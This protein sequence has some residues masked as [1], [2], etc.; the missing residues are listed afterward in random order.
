[1]AII[2]LSL[3]Y[4]PW[5]KE[6]PDGVAWDKIR[7]IRGEEWRWWL[8]GPVLALRPLH[9]RLDL[10]DGALALRHPQGGRLVGVGRH[11]GALG[12]GVEGTIDK[13]TILA[14]SSSLD[15]ISLNSA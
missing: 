15:I 1:M 13:I 6:S 2:H 5:T 7:D 10:P 8:E 14:I 3:A 4:I 9:A 11:L 12:R